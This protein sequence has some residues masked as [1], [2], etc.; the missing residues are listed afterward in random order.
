MS[1]TRRANYF[2]VERNYW[3]AM[4]W[5]MTAEKWEDLEHWKELRWR[6]SYDMMPGNEDLGDTRSGVDKPDHWNEIWG[7][8][9]KRGAKRRFAKHIR[10]LGKGIIRRELDEYWEEKYSKE[11]AIDLYSNPEGNEDMLW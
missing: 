8:Y 9:K 11:T 4:K 10:R 6:W 7:M 3:Q 1:R 5:P 2:F